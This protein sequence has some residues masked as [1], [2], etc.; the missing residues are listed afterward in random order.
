IVVIPYLSIL[1]QTAAVY[2]NIFAPY[3]GNDYI[4]EHHSL[5]GGGQETQQTDSEAQYLHRRQ[6]LAENYTALEIVLL[7]LMKLKLYHLN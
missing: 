6:Q 7:F 2:R 5:A 4:L 3:F 1:E